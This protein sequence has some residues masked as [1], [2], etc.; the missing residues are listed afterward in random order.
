[1]SKIINILDI[2]IDALT[3]AEA[4]SKLDNFVQHKKKNRIATI[5]TE[6]I[7][8][9]QSDEEFKEILL[10]NNLR[11]A[12][13]IGVLWGAKF[14][15]INFT[16]IPIIKHL[17][18]IIV[19]LFSLLTL[20]LFLK[21]FPSPIP[22]RIAGA[23]F[24]WDIA[25]YANDNSLKLFLLGGAPTVAE[26]TALELQTKIYG[27]KIAGVHSGG[28][29]DT[30]EIVS[31]INNSKADIIMVAFGAPKQEK[32]L[33]ENLKKTTCKIGIGV[34][35]SFDFIA[36]VR[37]RAPKFVQKIGFE[38]LYRLIQEP[39]RLKRQLSLPRFALILLK[40][41]LITNNNNK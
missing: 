32:W 23:D 36:G 5:N 38:W 15:S 10:Q 19:W 41:K 35:G 34:G 24:V 33:F 17:E 6:I 1:M 27:L 37:K 26:R 20:P 2:K 22:E 25:R 9:A 29:K 16:H 28:P 11:L 8:N 14:D 4:I 21:I 18:I 30:N 13:G 12:D 31:V 39:K 7:V 3:K 40:N